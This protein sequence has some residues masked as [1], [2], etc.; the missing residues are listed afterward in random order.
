MLAL[1]D[2]CRGLVL[3]DEIYFEVDLKIKCDGGEIKDFSRGIGAFEKAR[4]RASD[5]TMGINL[6]SW[7]S[8]VELTCAYVHRPVEATIAINVLKGPFNISKVVASTPGNFRDH[9]ILYE[10]AGGA[11]QVGLGEGGSF[12]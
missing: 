9:I 3:L 6:I 1:T 11:L 8:S 12:H 2:P 4:L 5:Q 7:L 10:A